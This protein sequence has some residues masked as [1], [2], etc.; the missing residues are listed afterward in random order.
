MLQ[1]KYVRHS[2]D[3]KLAKR[4]MEALASSEASAK[5]L[6][7]PMH[8]MVIMCTLGPPPKDMLVAWAGNFALLQCLL[9]NEHASPA[10]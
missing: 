2:L 6:I 4:W 5:A 8:Y 3:P 9:L 7:V 10:S 1:G